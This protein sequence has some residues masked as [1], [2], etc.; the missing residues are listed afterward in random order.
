LSAHEVMKL[1]K[2]IEHEVSEKNI[3]KKHQ[4]QYQ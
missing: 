1:I 4:Y 2:L 3:S